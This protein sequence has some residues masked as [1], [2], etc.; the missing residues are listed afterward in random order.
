VNW[1]RVGIPT[2]IM[3]IVVVH[4]QRVR[5]G[6][7]SG[8]TREAANAVVS[9]TA[10]KAA[11]RPVVTLSILPV[12][13]Y[14]VNARQRPP[15]LLGDLVQPIPIFARLCGPSRACGSF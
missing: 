1:A 8:R 7:D 12:V 10:Y 5:S 13:R 9:T 6:V 4:G 2:M 3:A 15:W 14:S 11:S